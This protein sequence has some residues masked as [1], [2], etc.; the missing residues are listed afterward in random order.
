ME[1]E[2]AFRIEKELERKIQ[3]RMQSCISRVTM[4]L[5]DDLTTQKVIRYLSHAANQGARYFLK[6]KT[7]G[8]GINFDL[9]S[10][11]EKE[12]GIELDRGTKALRMV[13]QL[14][15][16]SYGDPIR[17]LGASTDWLPISEAV[18]V[19]GRVPEYNDFNP[20]KV[21]KAIQKLPEGTKIS[22][23]RQGSVVIF[24]HH[25][26][27]VKRE[28]IKEFLEE[29][30]EPD[31]FFEQNDFNEL[32]NPYST[33]SNRYPEPKEGMLRLWWD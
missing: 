10:K 23:G 32:P 3:E 12:Q 11:W 22:I 7:D 33:V 6:E 14:Y 16:D 4:N 31:E 30:L 9:R 20:V 15:G 26:E 18:T 8:E 1:E 29:S 2:E 5:E 25:E 28:D 19:L 24:V 27:E 21:S 17:D 13:K